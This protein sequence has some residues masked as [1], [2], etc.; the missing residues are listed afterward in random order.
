M[1]LLKKKIDTNNK[2]VYTLKNSKD[3]ECKSE[4]IESCVL[5]KWFLASPL[6]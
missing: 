5:P 2:V 3:K 4:N 1:S 6:L